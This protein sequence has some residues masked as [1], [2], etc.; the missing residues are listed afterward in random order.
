MCTLNGCDIIII[1]L[2]IQF[3]KHLV[4]GEIIGGDNINICFELYILGKEG[5]G[6]LKSSKII[7][8]N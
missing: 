5:R 3:D 7:V 1:T 4:D 2:L 8:Q 6:T